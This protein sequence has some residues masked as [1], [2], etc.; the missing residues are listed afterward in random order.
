MNKIKK[1]LKDWADD[2]KPREKLMSKGISSLSDAELIAILIGSGNRNETAVELS[3]RILIENS[4]NLN[5]LGKLSVQEL[6]KYNGI[7]EAKAISIVASLE[8]GKRRAIS[9]FLEHPVITTMSEVYEYMSPL[10]ENLVHEEFWAIF[11]NN[12]NKILKR[13]KVSQG[14]ITSTVID[15]RLIMKAALESFSTAFI[16]CH[17]H[18]SGSI[19]PSEKDLIITQRLKNAGDIMEIKLLDHIII[20]HNDYYSFAG[21]ELL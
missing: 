15:V 20:G 3:R 9:G 16:V 5:Q 19:T 7:G 21:N 4:S 13:M 6:T 11:L 10:L 2:D 18:P 17:N 1:N 12:S 8:L 14:G